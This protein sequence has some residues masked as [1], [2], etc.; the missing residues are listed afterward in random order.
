LNRVG[1]RIWKLLA[2]P[3]RIDDLCAILLTEYRVDPN[4]CE[5]QVL[6]LLEELRAEGLI[7]IVERK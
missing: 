7:A 4:V 1:S 2:K 5:H 3:A 6:D